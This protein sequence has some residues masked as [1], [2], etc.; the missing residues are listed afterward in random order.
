MRFNKKEKFESIG[1]KEILR[2][3]KNPEYL[4]DFIKKIVDEENKVKTELE[5]LISFS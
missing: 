4:D 1:N 5:K 3:Y 2:M